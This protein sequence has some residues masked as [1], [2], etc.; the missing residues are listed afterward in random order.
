MDT[1][2]MAITLV[3]HHW[4]QQHRANAVVHPVTGKEMEYMA[5]MQDPSLQPLWKRGFGNEVGRL[6]QGIRD[7]PGTDTCFFVELTSIPKD[8]HITYGKIVKK[9]KERVRL[10]VGGDM[11]DYSGD[12]VTSTADITTFKILINSTLST[13]DAAMTMM[14]IKNY[15]LGTPLPRF[16]YMK[17][18]VK[19]LPL[20]QPPVRARTDAR[21]NP[22]AQRA[23]QLR[24]VLARVY[25][26][27]IQNQIT[28]TVP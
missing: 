24:S 6:F 3:N 22:S 17:M 4:F 20:P 18:F 11:L 26:V 9:E 21:T 23:T 28:T 1:A 15:Y 10:T 19:L 12:V 14:D 13:A 16:E 27:S 5:L 7:I 25:A 8:R 2:N